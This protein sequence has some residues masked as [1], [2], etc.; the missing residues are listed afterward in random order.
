MFTNAQLAVIVATA[1]LGAASV[2]TAY[3]TWHERRVYRKHMRVLI[4]QA[5]AGRHFIA[6][7]QGKAALSQEMTFQAAF[8]SLESEK[9][10]SA[11]GQET[12]DF[13]RKLHTA[14]SIMKG[15]K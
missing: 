7:V 6:E 10:V 13:Y 2:F 12:Y 15:A 5:F 14:A 9:N 1:L 3:A 4:A 11:I 8:L